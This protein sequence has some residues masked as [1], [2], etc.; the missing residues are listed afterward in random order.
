MTLER[1]PVIVNET[2]VEFY[3]A[4]GYAPSKLSLSEALG[5]AYG[6]LTAEEKKSLA[7]LDIG[8]AEHAKLNM[9]PRK[10]RERFFYKDYVFDARVEQVEVLEAGPLQSVV[11]ATRSV[12]PN[13]Q[14]EG[15]AE[16]CD[17]ADLHETRAEARAAMD[18]TVRREI[19]R[20]REA[21]ENLTRFLEE[22]PS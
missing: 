1:H 11:A 22:E 12:N 14:A 15:G 2:E 9:N 21:I 20:H 17:S 3:V 10:E 7:V 16:G 8:Q 13:T 4:R 6:L 18:A 5:K 19:E